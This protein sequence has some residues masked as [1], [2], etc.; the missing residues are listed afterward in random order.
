MPLW[1]TV[2]LS[3]SA[4]LS[5]PAIAASLIGSLVTR[6][7]QRRR[8]LEAIQRA[9]VERVLKVVERAAHR[10]ASWTRYWSASAAI[11][12]TVN[13]PRLLLEL[14]PSNQP[15]AS[16]LWRQTQ[17][18]L[19]ARSEQDTLRLGTDVSLRLLAWQQGAAPIAW[20]EE[21]LRR[22]PPTP[23]FVV[24]RSLRRRRMRRDVL[25]GAQ[26]ATEGAVLGWMVRRAI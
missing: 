14:G 22:D 3:V 5:L 10:Q 23:G 25:L 7:R 15:V 18:M 19:S 21:E 12:F 26:I 16:W 4:A 1:L 13:Y 24:P 20:F 11:D 2:T 9:T 6:R 8:E 17:Q